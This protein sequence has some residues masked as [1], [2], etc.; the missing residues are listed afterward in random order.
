MAAAR[1]TSTLAARLGARVRQLRVERS[2][3]QET[4]AW[5]CDFTKSHISQIE[6]GKSMPSIQA[7]AVLARLFDVHLMDFFSWDGADPRVA[8]FEALRVD[9]AAAIR[10][11]LR[12]LGVT[13]AGRRAER[14]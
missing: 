4:V 1:S 8:L 14:G 12:R 2:L 13:S 7:L 6:S 11:A 3:T 5:E 9:D 10:A